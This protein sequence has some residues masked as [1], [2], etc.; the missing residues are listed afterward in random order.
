MEH[1]NKQTNK[2][3]KESDL[4][5]FEAVVISLDSFLGIPDANPANLGQIVIH[6]IMTRN[7][8]NKN[9]RMYSYL[10][11]NKMMRIYFCKL[12]KRVAVLSIYIN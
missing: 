5:L 1:M 7:H 10:Y 11:S 4:E 12:P 9:L 8:L 2:Q 3:T 6:F